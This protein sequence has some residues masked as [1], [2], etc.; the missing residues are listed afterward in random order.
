[1][2]VIAKLRCAR[3]LILLAACGALISKGSSV[4]AD[5]YGFMPINPFG[6]GVSW[7]DPNN[8]TPFGLPGSGDTALIG[9]NSITLQGSFFIGALNSDAGSILYIQPSSTLTL[10]A[11]SVNRG[12]ILLNSNGNAS[13]LDVTGT[14]I[15]D[16]TA[17]SP[18]FIYFGTN[19][20]N[21]LAPAFNA[22]NSTLIIGANETVSNGNVLCNGEISVNVINNGVIAT[23]GGGLTI[24]A[25]T[26]TNNATISG[27]GTLTFSSTMVN[28]TGQILLGSG[29]LNLN[30]S[31]ISGGT[32]NFGSGAQL[33]VSNSSLI[34]GV[35]LAGS[36]SA[37]V[38]GALTMDSITSQITVNLPTNS[39]ITL[40]AANV[41]NGTI[42]L[43]DTDSYGGNFAYLHA[44]GNT[45]LSGSGKILFNSSYQNIIDQ[46]NVGDS[47]TI[48]PA[49]TIATGSAG[50]GEIRAMLFNNGTIDSN[51]G[52][53]ITFDSSAKSNAGLIEARNSALIS[54][55]GIFITNSSAG[56][57]QVDAT[58]MLNLSAGNIVGGSLNTAGSLNFFSSSSILNSTLTNS[59][60]M[61]VASGVTQLSG[62]LHNSTG[63]T[64]TI[65][66]NG[67][68]RLLEGSTYDNEGTISLNDTDSYGG[69]SSILRVMGNV[70][71]DG[72]PAH[73][74]QIAFT[75]GYQ[76]Y[77]QP[78]NV[79]TD[80][81]TLG[82]SQ[83]LSV[84]AGAAGY[85]S[86][87]I[88]NNG[89]VDAG[90]GYLE[91]DSVGLTNNH[92]VHIGAGGQIYLH[93]SSIT[94][95]AT[96]PTITIDAGGTLTLANATI[97]GG[98]LAGGGVM[99]IAI[100]S[101]ID[102]S[103]TAVTLAGPTINVP[104]SHSLTMHG[105]IANSS[106]INVSDSDGYGGN[107]AN[108]YIDSAVALSG[109][110]QILFGSPNQNNILPANLSAGDVLTIGASQTIM[111]TSGGSGTVGV[112]V[113]NNGTIHASGGAITLANQTFTN[114]NILSSDGGGSINLSSAV[115]LNSGGT[116]SLA[117]D[118]GLSLSGSMLAGG[119][120][121]ATPTSPISISNSTIAGG[122]FAT[123][124]TAQIAGSVLFNASVTPLTVGSAN[125]PTGATLIVQG[126]P[127]A[128]GTVRLVDTDSYGGN[129]AY[130]R[131]DGAATIDGTAASP[132]KILFDTPY[133]N[134]LIATNPVG[135]SL[136]IGSHETVLTSTGSA[137]LINVNVI[138]N[139]SID[140]AGGSITVAAPVTNNAMIRA[141]SAGALTI[142]ATTINNS[143]NG[144][145]L[146]TGDATVNI[147]SSSVIGGSITNAGVIN[148][149][150]AALSTT[151]N[152]IGS[153]TAS[154]G[155]SAVT[156]TF[157]NAP[158]ATFTVV[159]GG[160][161]RLRSGSTYD[162]R[163]AIVLNDTDNYGGN[164]AVLRIDGSVSIDGASGS[165]GQINFA[166]SNQNYILPMRSTDGLTIGTN[167]AI[168][169]AAGTSGTVSVN[170]NNIGAI[171]AAGGSISLSSISV[172]NGGA[173]TASA[174]GTLSVL[175]SFINSG[176]AGNLSVDPASA[177]NV[178]NSTLAGGQITGGGPLN[179]LGT[180]TLDGFTNPMTLAS[181]TVNVPTST[182]LITHGIINNN[183]AI[184]LTDTDNYGGNF[185]Y[186][187][188][189]GNSTIGGSG[190]VIFSTPYQNVI[191]AVSAGDSLTIGANQTVITAVGANGEISAALINNG[192]V[193]A[194]N[195]GTITLDSNTKTNNGLIQASAGGV[196][197]F[198]ALATNYSGNTLT[199]GS[200]AVV[201]SSTMRLQGMNITT[202]AAAITLDG[203]ASNLF[204]DNGSTS[205]LANF[206]SNTGS[207]TLTHGRT[208]ITAGNLANSGSITLGPSAALEVVGTLSNPGTIDLSNGSLIINYSGASPISDVRSQILS[209][210]L[211]SSF[212]AGDPQL[213]MAIGYAEASALGATMWAGLAVDSTTVITKA[214]Y[215]GDANLDGQV[216]ADDYALIDRGFAK[217][218]LDA[219]WSDGDFND[220]GVVNSAD[221]L[222]IDRVFTQQ[223]GVLSPELLA[224]REAQ[225][226]DQYVSELIA[227][228][229]EPSVAGVCIGVA[230]FARRR[231]S[232]A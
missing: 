145:V 126:P 44:S 94:S 136:T 45:I 26:V 77:L 225:F 174:G 227:S 150:P 206:A 209:G 103:A 87:N 134:Y 8:W 13:Q 170:V 171:N 228:I 24:D 180:D 229:P 41:N 222:L 177:L 226:G 105:S 124:G 75:T 46:V 104:T 107:T 64:L 183:S 43:A 207:L 93:S 178:T 204:S 31:T 71:V 135:D 131:A 81:L 213:R 40:H 79:F 34:G 148:L 83:S 25:P 173:L 115:L 187:Y 130:L 121:L 172:T 193:D 21:R 208:L 28:N 99:N 129:F 212:A 100:D 98:T 125:I 58:S 162:N 62:T 10:S 164:F 127:T 33:S 205:A 142:S 97:A 112:A 211:K 139:G 223:T 197:N 181:V 122:T 140:A 82:A 15:I 108:L 60:A 101:R 161:L 184:N 114:N 202:N 4:L 67:E 190:Q 47:L 143:T 147:A 217:H 219:H 84:A 63:G 39:A 159:T 6:D 167:E 116:V 152:N 96:S 163:G 22:P 153:A 220:D 35:T 17:A 214:T 224:L 69:N 9:N 85:V 218:S 221:Y 175:S 157:H 55:N 38:S 132:G 155:V 138:N 199:G 141:S 29:T 89:M 53:A 182:V 50:N 165:A 179:V 23:N 158:G 92:S 201:G 144:Q 215:Y 191:S 14:V 51:S 18:G 32:I 113:V 5:T 7:G 186:L 176:A 11:D 120:V 216:N 154:S 2:S 169:A 185:S 12:T 111:T 56:V 30:N 118:G 195:G 189:S 54:V 102:G 119:T 27:G 20:Q 95:S 106:V 68:L 91:F 149:A 188:A 210:H 133:Q 198:T 3:G 1:M 66:T 168:A 86:A 200:W 72:T 80:S 59:G 73:P 65:Q 90:S 160:E 196:I 76:N 78:G 49:E 70:A 109:T 156:G 232:Q 192:T 146:T 42:A 19:S 110:G 137:G 88:T 36:G 231:R 57:V 128:I 123:G 117:A 230:A 74:G 37:N 203:A 194:T 151:F 16:G 48:G 52:G 61:A 166:T